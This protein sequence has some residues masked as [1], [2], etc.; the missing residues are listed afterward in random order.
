[1]M[2]RFLH[3]S[4]MSERHASREDG[5]FFEIEAV[6]AVSKAECMTFAKKKCCRQA[7]AMLGAKSQVCIGRLLGSRRIPLRTWWSMGAACT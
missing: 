7:G 2:A 3:S 4:R 6:Q 5:I 1:M